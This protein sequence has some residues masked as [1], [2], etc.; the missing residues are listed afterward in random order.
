[1]SGP[2]ALATVG[3]ALNY[4]AEMRAHGIDRRPPPSNRGALGSGAA[5]DR[6]ARPDRGFIEQPEERLQFADKPPREAWRNP[7]PLPPEQ[8][9]PT[10]QIAAP[11]IETTIAPPPAAPQEP[12]RKERGPDKKKRRTPIHKGMSPLEFERLRLKA[13]RLVMEDG[14]HGSGVRVAKML[15]V[16]SGAVTTWVKQW[17]AKHG[18]KTL[19][20]LED[21]SFARE[22]LLS[23]PSPPPSEPVAPESPRE[24]IRAVVAAPNVVVNA[25]SLRAALEAFIQNAVDAR[26]DAAIRAHMKRVWE[27]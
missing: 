27:R 9:K 17:K 13:I 24:S 19:P 23:R 26:V 12:E 18:R 14:E 21:P 5:N 25:P 22:T 16:S 7:A 10:A 11:K 2:K 15:N 4:R 8:R 1:M 20:P 6:D 3:D